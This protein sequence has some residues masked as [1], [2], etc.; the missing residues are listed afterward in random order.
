[1]TQDI[2][3]RPHLVFFGWVC[4][5]LAAVLSW[6]AVFQSLLVVLCSVMMT[7]D[8]GSVDHYWNC[9]FLI[10][11]VQFV[12]GGLLALVFGGLTYVFVQCAWWTFFIR[13]IR[14]ALSLAR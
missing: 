10:H 7:V 12:V 6:F 9:G 14:A 4:A 1:M 8:K 13:Q 5:C 3:H 2:A 11:G